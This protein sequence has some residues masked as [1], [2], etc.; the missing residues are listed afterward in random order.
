M[1]RKH[2]KR[3]FLNFLVKLISLIQKNFDSSEKFYYSEEFSTQKIGGGY[4]KFRLN[5]SEAFKKIFDVGIFEN[6][7]AAKN[8]RN[9]I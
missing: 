6:L 4:Y 2:S 8:E 3:P 9:C 5:G 1:N 7:V